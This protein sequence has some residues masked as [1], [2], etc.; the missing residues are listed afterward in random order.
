MFSIRKIYG[1]AVGLAALVGAGCDRAEP[2]TAPARAAPSA[3]MDVAPEVLQPAGHRRFAVRIVG[4]ASPIPARTR[5]L[6]LWMPVPQDDGLQTITK[7]TFSRAPQ[8]S[9]ESKYGNRVAYWE[10]AAPGSD[11][12]LEMRFECLRREARVDREALRAEGRDPPG[13][14]E[15][16]RNADRLVTLDPQVR[17]LSDRIVA[18]RQGTMEKARAIYDYVLSAMVYDKS[19]PGWGTGSTRHACEVGKGNCT[20]FHALFN[21]LCRAQGIASG[22]EI[23]LYLPYERGSTENPGGYHCWALFRVPGRS[24]VPVDCSEASRRPDRRDY[25][26]GGHTPNRVTLSRG[27]DLTLAPAQAGGPINYFLNPYAE[28]DGKPVPTDQSWS[29]EDLD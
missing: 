15:V 11:M 19:H 17:E 20:D 18:G 5:R 13:E 21:S 26:F 14:F 10:W 28:A 24:W 16:Y 2:A 25:F 22:F 8:L 1:L 4:R 6:R 12:E 23:G 7:L 29:Y 27:R 3:R 9:T